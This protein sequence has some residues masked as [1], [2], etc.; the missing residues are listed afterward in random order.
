MT[1][2]VLLVLVGDG[3]RLAL[4]LSAPP[5]LVAFLTALVVRAIQA[6]TQLQGAML[7]FLPRALAVCA[8]LLLTG[9]W[10]AEELKAYALYAFAWIAK[11]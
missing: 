9:H 2:D 4:T 11:I 1:D 7:A 5:V 6:S 10:M 3:L 8:T